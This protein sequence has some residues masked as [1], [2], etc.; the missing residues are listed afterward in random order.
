MTDFV[1]FKEVTSNIFGSQFNHI[2]YRVGSLKH[3]KMAN[4][5]I[6]LILYFM[7]KRN[8]F[9][10]EGGTTSNICWAIQIS[11]QYY[12][13]MSTCVVGNTIRDLAV[14]SKTLT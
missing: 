7:L 9:N 11:Q 1:R 12:R 8:F 4:L 3:I 14:N 5:N 2:K 10:G 6:L 13:V